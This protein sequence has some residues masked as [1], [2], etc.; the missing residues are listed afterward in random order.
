MATMSNISLLVAVVVGKCL[1]DDDAVVGWWRIGLGEYDV[2]FDIVGSPSAPPFNI[3]MYTFTRSHVRT[4]MHR[5]P[6]VLD[7]VP[8]QLLLPPASAGGKL[9]WALT[10]GRRFR[11]SASTR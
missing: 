1:C 10:W 3:Q 2:S 9:W 4:S 8:A 11:S 7:Q 5:F 6:H